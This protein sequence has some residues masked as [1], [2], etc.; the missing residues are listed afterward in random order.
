MRHPPLIG[1]SECGPRRPPTN[2]APRHPSLR[3]QGAARNLRNPSYGDNCGRAICNLGFRRFLSGVGRLRVTSGWCAVLCSYGWWVGTPTGHGSRTVPQGADAPGLR[4]EV[5]PGRWAGTLDAMDYQV[6][7][8]PDKRG[9]QTRGRGQQREGHCTGRCSGSE[10][11]HAANR[12]TRS[13]QGSWMRAKGHGADHHLG[14][15]HGRAGNQR[16]CHTHTSRKVGTPEVKG[17]PTGPHP[18]SITVSYSAANPPKKPAVTGFSP[19]G[20]A[21][22]NL[23][24]RR[25]LASTPYSAANTRFTSVEAKYVVVDSS[26]RGGV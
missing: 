11:S 5:D 3:G 2:L 16:R 24:S 13:A 4:R 12:R 21:S 6:L 26:I 15:T 10:Q 7:R 23:D 1:S 9:C 18:Y 20:A 22:P 8:D 14:T 19:A 17:R 25:T